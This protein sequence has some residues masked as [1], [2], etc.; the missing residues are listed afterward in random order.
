MLREAL[1]VSLPAFAASIGMAPT[2]VSLFERDQLR[3]TPEQEINVCSALVD[4]AVDAARALAAIRYMENTRAEVAIGVGD[5]GQ[6]EL[7]VTPTT[8]NPAYS[9][10]GYSLT[11]AALDSIKQNG[12]NQ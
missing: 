3:I 10:Y 6:P 8:L 2:S 7:E 4:A 5:N 12:G 9:G 11:E 1:R